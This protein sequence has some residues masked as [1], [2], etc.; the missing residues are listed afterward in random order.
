MLLPHLYEEADGPLER[1][2]HFFATHIIEV[3]KEDV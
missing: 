2:S 1:S 3:A